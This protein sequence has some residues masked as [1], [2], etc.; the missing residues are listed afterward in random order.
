[1]AVRIF[2]KLFAVLNIFF[3]FYYIFSFTEGTSM[4][5]STI[6]YLILFFLAMFLNYQF[7]GMKIQSLL[8]L[9]AHSLFIYGDLAENEDTKGM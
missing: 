9:I 2:E 7:E 8:Y 4:N 3:V 6:T 5:P 1:M